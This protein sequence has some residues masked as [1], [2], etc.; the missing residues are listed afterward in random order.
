LLAVVLEE[1]RRRLAPRTWIPLVLAAA[2]AVPGWSEAMLSRLRPDRARLA[3]PSGRSFRELTDAVRSLPSDSL[4]TA[5]PELSERIPALTG[6]RV[7]AMSDRATIVFA[8]NRTDGEARMRARA[9]LM[10]GLWRSRD[11]VP[12]PTHVLFAPGS[13]AA[14]YCGRTL[15]KTES[16]R[17]CE[18]VAAEPPPGVRMQV[19][20]TA[21]DGPQ[22]AELAEL[23][24]AG[25]P[26]LV[27]DCSPLPAEE[28]PLLQWPR[29][30]PW[31]ARTVELACKIYAPDEGGPARL[32]PRTLELTPNLGAAVDEFIVT[33]TGRLAG[34]QRWN[35]RTR[36]RARHGQALRFVLPRG[37]I[38][39]LS[40]RVIP[41]LLPFL[42]LS[43]LTLTF[44]DVPR[45]HQP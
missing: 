42:K 14:R 38:D 11:G 3:A 37:A 25:D 6:R 10:A 33:A 28:A 20:T 40:F 13:R 26:W 9:A 17:L 31:S 21:G 5:A 18:F 29:P 7:L 19:A 23:L 32:R 34:K 8:G 16:W 43:D 4:I 44:E 45:E 24:T 1:S 35:V 27:A 41:T 12:A 36:V 22:R 39:T 15:L 30:G 2:L